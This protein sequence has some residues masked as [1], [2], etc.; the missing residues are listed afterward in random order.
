LVCKNCHKAFAYSKIGNTLGDFFL[1]LRPE[2]P[3][4]GVEC[5][6]PNCKV[7]AIYQRNE[8]RYQSEAKSGETR[9]RLVLW[10]GVAELQ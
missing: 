1:P 9:F 4:E 8:L 6:C 7:Q 3:P 10:R 2:I 5:E